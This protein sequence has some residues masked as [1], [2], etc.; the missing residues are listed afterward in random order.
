MATTN[1]REASDWPG[2]SDVE[3]PVRS[4]ADEAPIEPVLEARRRLQESGGSNLSAI[5]A[6]V[7]EFTRRYEALPA[8][9]QR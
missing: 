1:I 6:A 9:L 4:R 7:D 5:Q 3:E 2:E 8:E